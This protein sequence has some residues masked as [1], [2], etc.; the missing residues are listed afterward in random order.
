MYEVEG[1][2]ADSISCICILLISIRSQLDMSVWTKRCLKDRG[3]S[4]KK[5]LK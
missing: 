1:G 5:S 2:M 4:L 3:S